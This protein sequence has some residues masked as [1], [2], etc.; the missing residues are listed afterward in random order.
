[1]GGSWA[2]TGSVYGRGDRTGLG[3]RPLRQNPLA[4]VPRFH[5]VFPTGAL[6]RRTG[7]WQLDGRRL[8]NGAGATGEG[9]GI[10]AGGRVNGPRGTVARGFYLRTG[11]QGGASEAFGRWPPTR[12]ERPPLSSTYWPTI[13][14]RCGLQRTG[15]ALASQPIHGLRMEELRTGPRSLWERKDGEG[16]ALDRA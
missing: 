5:G 7:K 10:G 8:I 3:L 13:L 11:F 15:P 9:G 1:M 14:L 6:S 2:G 4:K 12:K 16:W